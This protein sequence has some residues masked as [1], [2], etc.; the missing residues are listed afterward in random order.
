MSRR[1]PKDMAAELK[2]FKD[3]VFLLNKLGGLIK[4]RLD[5]LNDYDHNQYELH[6]FIQYSLYSQNEEWFIERGIKQKLI[7]VSK[8]CHE[9]IE[10]RGIK[11]LTD[12]EFEGKYKISRWK[13]LYNRKHFDQE[14]G[15][16]QETIF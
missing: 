10:N 4:I 6:H 5:S 13:L 12:A 1:P 9:H 3:S 8:I 15:D 2:K 11:T 14:K 16:Y 7:L